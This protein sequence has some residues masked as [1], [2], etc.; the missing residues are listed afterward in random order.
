ML[1]DV[2]RSVER[3]SCYLNN[4][5]AD[6]EGDNDECDGDDDEN[7]NDMNAMVVTVQNCSLFRGEDV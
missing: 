4:A 2:W 5:A 3:I 1:I 6:N 7:D